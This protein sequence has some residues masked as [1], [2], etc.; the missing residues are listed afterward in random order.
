MTFR[1]IGCDRNKGENKDDV[2]V[3]GIINLILSW[4][5][6]HSY[7]NNFENHK[8]NAYSDSTVIYLLCICVQFLFYFILQ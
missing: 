1:L 2:A 7:K 5:A 8:L 4:W 6:E 3:W